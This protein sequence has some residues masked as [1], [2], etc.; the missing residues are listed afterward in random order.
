MRRSGQPY[1]TRVNEIILSRRVSIIFFNPIKPA[2]NPIF[3]RRSPFNATHV[4]LLKFCHAFDL[5]KIW[6]STHYARVLSIYLF[7]DTL[8]WSLFFFSPFLS[9][10]D[11]G[12]VK[13]SL[14]NTTKR[15]N[16]ISWFEFFSFVNQSRSE[17]KE[18][19]WLKM[20]NWKAI[21]KFGELII[22]RDISLESLYITIIA[23]YL[24]S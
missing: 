18:E 24:L 11:L 17:R 3:S 9:N 6:K 15:L 1:F 21:I 14:A 22:L 4:D 13:R 2:Q 5:V 19:N 8:P 20:N 16:N 23:K 7:L 12:E 10:K